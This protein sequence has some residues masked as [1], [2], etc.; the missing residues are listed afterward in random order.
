MFSL[1]STIVTKDIFHAQSSGLHHQHSVSLTFKH[2][3]SEH[4]HIHHSTW[5]VE[6]QNFEVILDYTG[7]LR[8]VWEICLPTKKKRDIQ[9]RKDMALTWWG[10]GSRRVLSLQ[11]DSILYPPF[12]SNWHHDICASTQTCTGAWATLTQLLTYLLSGCF[13]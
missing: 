7:S 2:S 10:P 5:E 1:H 9:R 3:G 4:A 12:G 8:P 6:D 11:S 13:P